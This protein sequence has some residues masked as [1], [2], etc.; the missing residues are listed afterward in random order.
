MNCV[1]EV[2]GA[3]CTSECI[4]TQLKFHYTPA[5]FDITTMS[6]AGGKKIG[7]LCAV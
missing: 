3:V 1:S 7:E 4:Y 5:D 2:L 6:E